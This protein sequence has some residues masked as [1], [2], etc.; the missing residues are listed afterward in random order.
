MVDCDVHSILAHVNIFQVAI[1][2]KRMTKAHKI[3][4]SICLMSN[5]N[6]D[7]LDVRHTFRASH[8]LSNNFNSIVELGGFNRSAVMRSLLAEWIERNSEIL[9][10]EQ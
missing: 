2:E 7:G 6:K 1:V 4:C 3:T 5:K 8:E 9:G 10:T